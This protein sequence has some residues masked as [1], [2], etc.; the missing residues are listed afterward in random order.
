MGDESVPQV[1]IGDVNESTQEGQERFVEDWG[2]EKDGEK[3]GR[4]RMSNETGGTS[5][6]VVLAG[7]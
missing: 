2:S 6:S 1:V 7:R 5:L 3:R 4:S